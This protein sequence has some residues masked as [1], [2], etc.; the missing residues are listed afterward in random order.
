MQKLGSKGQQNGTKMHLNVS[1]LAQLESFVRRC[2][3]DE[4]YIILNA[5]TALQICTLFLVLV[6][7]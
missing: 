5:A 3:K 4:E 2:R 1:T 7:S 6:Q